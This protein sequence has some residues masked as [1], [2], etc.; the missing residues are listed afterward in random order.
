MTLEEVLKD[1]FLLDSGNSVLVLGMANS[2]KS[3]LI[4][5]K[6]MPIIDKVFKENIYINMVGN[7]TCKHYKKDHILFEQFNPDI[8]E[9]ARLTNRATNNKYKYWFIFD[10]LINLRHKNI[11]TNLLLTLRNADISSIVSIQNPTL[12]TKNQRSNFRVFI[13]LK[14]AT[15]EEI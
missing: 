3:Y 6:L 4:Y 14:Y 12:L 8:L 2:G 10:D 9:V 5:N 15:Y 1:A 7:L 11:M 13:F